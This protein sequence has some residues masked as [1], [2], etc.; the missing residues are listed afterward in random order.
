MTCDTKE[1]TRTTAPQDD[2][3]SLEHLKP[4]VDNAEREGASYTA[5]FNDDVQVLLDGGTSPRDILLGMLAGEIQPQMVDCEQFEKLP[6]HRRREFVQA[7]RM[8]DEIEKCH[9]NAKHSCGD[10]ILSMID[11]CDLSRL[12]CLA[13]SDAQ[14]SHILKRDRS[15]VWRTI[16]LLIKKGT[17]ERIDLVD[18]RAGVR[19]RLDR[20]GYVHPV[21]YLDALAPSFRGRGRLSAEQKNEA[22]KVEQRKIERAKQQVMI[23]AGAANDDDQIVAPSATIYDQM[24][25]S[26]ATDIPNSVA[27]SATTND[28]DGLNR[29]AGLV[30]SLRW[31][32]I[33]HCN[34][35]ETAPPETSLR[36][37]SILSKYLG[38]SGVEG[39]HTTKAAL[40]LLDQA[41]E[42]HDLS[43]R[44][45]E[46]GALLLKAGLPD[47]TVVMLAGHVGIFDG[48]PFGGIEKVLDIAA[49]IGRQPEMTSDRVH[50]WREAMLDNPPESD[51]QIAEVLV[52]A[53][54]FEPTEHGIC[55]EQ[56]FTESLR[57]PAYWSKQLVGAGLRPDVADW[58]VGQDWEGVHLSLDVGRFASILRHFRADW[59]H[60]IPPMAEADIAHWIKS[61]PAEDWYETRKVAHQLACNVYER[62]EREK[63]NDDDFWP[64]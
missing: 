53:L 11:S 3:D 10:A 33:S 55:D 35:T 18:G 6:A 19:R 38:D 16:D 48:E 23:I 49:R 22:E 42:G 7:L 40:M 61:I 50:A 13:M 32:K 5:A 62:L 2:Q 43:D 63:P 21:A 60:L 57:T 30:K 26:S 51:D 54:D 24:V 28:D 47:C 64:F 1:K 44:H 36:N 56:A 39:G 45:F 41:L 9:L 34:Q 17:V 31:P 14:I 15:N 46:T 29:C 8:Q 52:A 20:R 27:P 4:S 37:I 25:A 12:G 58:A 59:R